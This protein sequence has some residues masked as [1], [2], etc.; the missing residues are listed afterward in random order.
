MQLLD[1]R[2]SIIIPVLNEA[3]NILPTLQA[4][5]TWRKRG[6]EVIVVDGQSRDAT[7]E[8][9]GP[10]CDKLLI[11]PTGRAV[12]MNSGA[13]QA[14]GNILLFLHADT[15]LPDNAIEAMIKAIKRS[16]RVWGRFDIRLSGHHPLLWVV[17]MMMNLRSR[18][19]GIATGD[20]AIFVRRDVF[21][22][23]H[24]YAAIALMEDVSLSG[25]LLH[26][27]RPACIRL[28]AVTSSRRWEQN[29]ILRTILLMWYLRLA[30]FLGTPAESLARIYSRR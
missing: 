10:L 2:V 26:L 8:L 24:G 20:Q 7:A 22:R 6:H 16:G 27:S 17:G 5:Q 1:Y 25:K 15:R 23:V 14:H 11:S 29:G 30:Y 21:H 12:Q 3:A 13:A 19:T 4:L 18:L 9:A 28:K